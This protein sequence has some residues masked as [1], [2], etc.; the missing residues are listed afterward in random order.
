MTSSD[1]QDAPA[2]CRAAGADGLRSSQPKLRTFT[3]A[4]STCNGSPQRELT[5]NPLSGKL[6]ADQ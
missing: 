3:A 6:G 2:G 4:M 1:M 5:T